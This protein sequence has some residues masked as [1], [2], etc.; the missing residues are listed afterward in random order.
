MSIVGTVLSGLNRKV[1]T[2]YVLVSQK[3]DPSL[4][5]LISVVFMKVQV[6]DTVLVHVHVT[7]M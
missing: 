1:A 4:Y 5:L 6:A 7:C 2:I 3:S